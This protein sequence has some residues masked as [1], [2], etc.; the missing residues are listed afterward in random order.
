[1]GKTTTLNW[2]IDH[3]NRTRRCR[4]IT[5]E[6]PIEFMHRNVLANV[7]QREVGNDCTNFA[8]ALVQSLRQDPDVI[9]VGEMRDLESISTALTAAE[10]GHLVLSTLHTP[11]A[12]LTVD[13]IVDVFPSS[14]QNQIR[15]QLANVL[16][17]IMSQQL[18]RRASGH[19]RVL[20]CELLLAT[21]AIRHMIRDNHSAQLHSQMST[22]REQGMITMEQ[23]VR[24]LLLDGIV[25]KEEAMAH[26]ADPDSFKNL[27]DMHALSVAGSPRDF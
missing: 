10:T 3:I 22:S 6:D 17:G 7:A 26:V 19:G 5:I 12:G 8:Q 4:I 24:A 27:P 25:T 11:S 13:R 21:N 9:C 23:S 16:T 18:L 15:I 14:I 1:V 2:M 20:A